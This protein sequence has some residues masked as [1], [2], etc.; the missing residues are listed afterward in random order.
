MTKLAKEIHPS[1]NGKLKARELSLDSYKM[2]WWKCKNGPDHEWEARIHERVH[3]HSGC[4]FCRNHR[5]SVTNNLAVISPEIAS[6]WHPSKNGKTKPADVV[7]YTTSPYWFL[8]QQGHSYNKPL[9]L[10]L[11]YGAGCPKCRL[12]DKAQKAK[13]GKETQKSSKPQALAA[14][15]AR[16]PRAVKVVSKV[17]EESAGKRQPRL[18][19]EP[20]SPLKRAERPFNSVYRGHV[21]Q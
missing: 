2:I 20:G 12:E 11:R 17:S 19:A 1:L 3:K 15:A 14:K 5:L 10:R 4:P 6:E 16:T 8:C 21:V 13:Q 7:A 18:R 9:H